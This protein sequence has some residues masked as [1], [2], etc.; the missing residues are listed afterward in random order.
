MQDSPLRERTKQFAVR[1]IRL[2][3]KLPKSG[4]AKVIGNQLLRSAT[5][6][7]ANY[8][9]ACRSRTEAE[10]ISK[11]G[12]VEQELDESILWLELICDAQIM[13]T[14]LLIEIREEAEQLLRMTVASIRT[15]KSHKLPTSAFKLP[16]PHSRLP[17]LLQLRRV[18]T[19]RLRR[20]ITRRLSTPRFRSLAVL[21][22]DAPSFR[23]L[24]RHGPNR[25]RTLWRHC[26]PSRQ[27][28]RARAIA[29]R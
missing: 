5:S 13:R 29:N 8:R 4:E 7:A 14:D 1:V 28:A 18:T 10:M 23:L 19:I 25:R 3:T 6:V 11:L 20:R 27:T 24:L 2:Y 22:H 21:G 17:T 15:L 9:E 16:T 26:P 12:I